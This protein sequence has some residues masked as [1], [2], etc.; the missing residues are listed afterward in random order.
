MLPAFQMFIK[1]P[2]C[3][4]VS[5]VCGHIIDLVKYQTNMTKLSDSASY[6]PMLAKHE[7]L[8]LLWT[9]ELSDI[10][11]IIKELS[12]KKVGLICI[13]NR[14]SPVSIYGPEM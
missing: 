9:R 14:I 7:Q 13:G 4:L 5:W 10:F 11:I 3:L 6:S 12:K 8:C 1:A 2:F